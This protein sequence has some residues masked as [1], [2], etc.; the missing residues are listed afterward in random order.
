MKHNDIKSISVGTKQSNINYR[1]YNYLYYYERMILAYVL[2]GMLAA[3]LLGL[4]MW[5]AIWMTR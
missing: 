5:G 2:T 1:W 3:I 4:T